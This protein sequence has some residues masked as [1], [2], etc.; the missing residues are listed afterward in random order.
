MCHHIPPTTIVTSLTL[1]NLLIPH[2]L[3]AI[4]CTHLVTIYKLQPS[5]AYQTQLYSVQSVPHRQSSAQLLGMTTVSAWMGLVMSRNTDGMRIYCTCNH[6][7]KVPYRLDFVY[8]P[9]VDLPWAVQLLACREALSMGRVLLCDL[10]GF[11]IACQ[12]WDHYIIG[13]S[14]AT[15]CTVMVWTYS[16]TMSPFS[17][18]SAIARASWGKESI[19]LRRRSLCWSRGVY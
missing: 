2:S 19:S 3:L 6:Y 18:S 14:S 13:G 7:D 17:L 15:S 12:T 5:R 11:T 8:H 10:L 16:V 4:S 1:S 9:G